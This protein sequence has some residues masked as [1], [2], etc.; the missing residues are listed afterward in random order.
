MSD[1]RPTHP[2]CPICEVP[3]WLVRAELGEIADHQHFECK[4]CDRKTARTM[5]AELR[6]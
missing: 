1:L 4:V 2:H 5:P 6:V 3:M